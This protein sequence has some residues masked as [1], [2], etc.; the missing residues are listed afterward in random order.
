MY[1]FGSCC[2]FGHVSLTH[3]AADIYN[4]VPVTVLSVGCPQPTR[5]VKSHVL[6]P[7]MIP[8]SKHGLLFKQSL[9]LAHADS[10]DAHV[11]VHDAWLS[12]H[13]PPFRHGCDPHASVVLV[14]VV[15]DV[16]LV[17]LL[18]VDVLLG[19]VD[20]VVDDNEL[21]V[22]LVLLAAV[23]QF[24]PLYPVAQLQLYPY[25]S[26]CAFGHVVSMHVAADQYSP[27][28]VSVLV[29]WQLI[30]HEMS[31]ADAPYVSATS[32]Q[33]MLL[34]Q[35]TLPLQAAIWLEHTKLQGPWLSTHVPPFKHG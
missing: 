28:P 19:T 6:T 23:S 14:L 25:P 12:T 10:N 13:S 7:S 21:V 35:S 2:A 20:V 4:A 30:R 3:T 31:H 29:T 26:F 18:D 16:R 33:L 11:I 24:M 5:H 8:T 22:V 34:T 27:Y 17:V 9:L 32:R 1:A 15:V